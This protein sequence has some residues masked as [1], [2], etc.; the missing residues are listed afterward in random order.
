MKNL[1]TRAFNGECLIL[2]HET[3][4]SLLK[5]LDGIIIPPVRVVAGLV[6]VPTGGIK[7]YR[8]LVCQTK[9]N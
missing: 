2:V 5:G 3:L 6:V 8:W 4:G 9:E 1:V 7:C